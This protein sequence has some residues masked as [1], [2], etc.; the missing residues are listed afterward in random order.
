MKKNLN[1]II[2]IIIVIVLGAVIWINKAPTPANN[3]ENYSNSNPE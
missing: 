2:A 3:V 1:I